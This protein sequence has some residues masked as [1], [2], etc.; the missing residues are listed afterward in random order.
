MCGFVCLFGGNKNFHK[1]SKVLEK[2]L[3][4]FTHRGPDHQ[5]FYK[6]NFF[7]CS[8]RRLSIQDLNYRSNQPFKSRDSKRIIVFNGE[9]Y[10]FMDLRKELK[11]LGH[12]FYTN[13][14]TEVIDIAYKA[15]GENFVKKLRGMFSICI[16]EINNKKIF[17]AR[18]R[19][20]IKPL[21]FY[22]HEDIFF[23]SSEIKDITS[24]FPQNFFS[25]NDQTI[26]KYL[27][28]SSLEDTSQTFFN[29]I[30]KIEPSTMG[31]FYNGTFKKKKYWDLNY[32]EEDIDENSLDLEEKFTESIKYH[33][34]SDVPVAFTLSGGIDSSLITGVAKTIN[35]G[36]ELNFFSI[37]PKNTVDESFWINSTVKKYE[38]K[39]NYLLDD[40]IKL[41]NSIDELLLFHDEPIQSS[42]AIYQF[43]LRKFV[44]EKNFKVLMVGEGAD[45]VFSGYRR[46]LNYYLYH[47]QLTNEK[48]EEY[49][50]K[51]ESFMGIKKKEIIKNFFNF[52]KKI[53]N[54]SFDLED[55]SSLFFIRKDSKTYKS[56]INEY[57]YLN[58]DKKNFL[59]TS[60]KSHI[61]KNDLPYVLRM[62]DRNSMANS[63]ESRVPFLDHILVENVFKI[64]SSLF[65][66]NG[67]N[68]Y[69]LR[70]IFKKYFSDEVVQR[71][72]KSPRP[73]SNYFLMFNEFFNQF[74]E[75][76][77]SNDA[78]SSNFFNSNLILKTFI[79]DKKN[80]I[81]SNTDFYFRVFCYLKWKNLL[82]SH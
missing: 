20:G 63:I 29:D 14:D 44:R 8:F 41:E 52:K 53:D 36:N 72:Q 74:T 15:W 55:Q 59:K 30:N 25:E 70:E 56:W 46:C 23:L 65:M 4:K 12:D 54:K 27:Y 48:L 73:G 3:L 31:Y 71:E 9:I 16:Y 47:M 17:F 79:N 57:R 42:N 32:C 35:N 24:M 43:Y 77:G 60:L 82:N 26:I 5:N 7:A 18:D 6:D 58:F 13:G 76:L 28:R 40:E 39:H 10:N 68:K 64:K 37:K 78:K 45:E 1:F 11:D 19:F 34:V 49:A 22:R 61:F 81:S 80:N 2:N 38:L 62:E 67:K 69:L 66:K 51:S 33:M 21:Y 75:M 50:S